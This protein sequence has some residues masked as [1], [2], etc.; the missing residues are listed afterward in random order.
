MYRKETF[1][2]HY[3]DFNSFVPWRFRV[4][5]MR[6]LVSRAKRICDKKYLADELKTIKMFSAWNNFPVKVR[7]AL[8]RQ[9]SADREPTHDE[10]ETEE[11]EID[12]W[13]KLPYIGHHGE[14]LVKAFVKKVRRML[15]TG[16]KVNFKIR[17]QTTPLSSFTSVKDRTPFLNRSNVVYEVSCPGCGSSYIGKTDR[18][19]FERTSEHAW[20][21]QASTVRLHIHECEAFNHIFDM[22]NIEGS[23]F[24][25]TDVVQENHGNNISVAKNRHSITV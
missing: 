17:F 18:T 5:W 11:D 1:T 15:K 23:L 7:N 2:G 4:S 9:F 12:I 8:I 16:K 21:D 22:L 13:L 10:A 25:E 14:V 6:S 3:S 20:T 24:D 19:L